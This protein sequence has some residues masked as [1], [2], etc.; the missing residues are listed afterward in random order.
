MRI[1][2]ISLTNF[3]SFRATQNIDIAPV[4]LLFGPNSVGKS[5]ILLALFYVQQ[6]LKHGHCDPLR[7]DALG[8]KHVG[9]FRSLV[10]G[11]DPKKRITIKI[12][13][14]KG[15]YIGSSY[16][17]LSE[18]FDDELGLTVDSPTADANKVAV[19]L[20]IAWSY[21]KGEGY[22]YVAS[23]KIWLDDEKIAELSS[24]AGT[25]QPMIDYLNYR[26]PA[27]VCEEDSDYETED[28]FPDYVSNF[29][30]VI[31]APRKMMSIVPDVESLKNKDIE[32]HEPIGFK[33]FAG[34]LP[35]LGSVLETTLNI[36]PPVMTQ[37][38]HEILSDVVVA[39]LDNLLL[40]LN[41]SLCIGPLRVVP[42]SL[43]SR[44]PYPNQR[45][46]YDGTAAWEELRNSGSQVMELNHWMNK[47][48]TL[49]LGYSVRNKSTRQ[50]I[51]YSGSE[52]WTGEMLDMLRGILSREVGRESSEKLKE[53]VN[54][55][56]EGLRAEIRKELEKDESN[57]LDKSRFDIVLWDDVNGIE[58]NSS[59]VGVGVSQLLPLVVAAVKRPH[60]L[61]ACEQPELHVHPRVQVGI[62]DLLLQTSRGSKTFLI[63]THSE[64]L[65]LRI[66]K[67]IR[68]TTDG[69]LPENIDPVSPEHVS[70]TYLEPGPSG[71]ISR[72]IEIDK[73][74]EFVQRWPH[75]FFTERG[76]ELF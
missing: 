27:L 37:R 64:H 76:E 49:N 66:L 19:E 63:E 57:I 67:R 35:K 8:N 60:G 22:A 59:E 28:S 38:V 53:S 34:A 75:G 6:I 46:W 52:N 2:Q 71:V 36:D 65:I 42:D 24:D 74:G 26:H 73:E 10:N 69:E 62:G 20:S 32:F 1:T 31:N 16:N 12:I 44:N 4:T 54:D 61:I 70:I 41:E 5:S 30:R 50:V 18:L 56:P 23:Y 51:N 15:D 3:R 7:I 11:R 40:L 21:S 33:G 29:Q 14:K 47:P 45:D 48:D 72:R 55:L 13:Y 43:S 9:G 39:P 17:K 58:I 68:Q 25:K